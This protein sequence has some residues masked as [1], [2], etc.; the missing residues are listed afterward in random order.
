MR[1]PLWA[2]HHARSVRVARRPAPVLDAAL[3]NSKAA[4][5]P[6]INV[7]PPQG[8]FLH[9]LALMQGAKRILEIGTLGGYSTIWLAQALGPDGILI[10]LESEPHHAQIAQTNIARAAL[11]ATVQTMIGPAVDSLAKLVSDGAKP[12]DFIF[13]DAD[14][15]RYPEYL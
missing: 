12:F 6:M 1:S 7:S 3:E 10:T 13:I 14:K 9:L 11:T 5:L 15:E 8:K 4:G 2:V